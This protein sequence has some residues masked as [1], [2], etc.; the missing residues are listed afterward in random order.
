MK[1]YEKRD[2][3]IRKGFLGPTVSQTLKSIYFLAPFN[4]TKITVELWH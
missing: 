4:S 1:Y 3:R 2:E